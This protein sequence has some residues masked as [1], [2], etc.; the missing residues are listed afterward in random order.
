MKRRTVIAGLPFLLAGHPLAA[1]AQPQAR[2]VALWPFGENDAEGQAL[3]A[4]FNAALLDRGQRE[5]LIQHRWGGADGARTRALAV[6]A[7]RSQ[8]QVIFTYLNAQLRA[9]TALSHTIPLVFVGASD[10]AGFGL[11]ENLSRPGGHVTGF[12]LYE[13]SLGGKWLAALQ[14]AV[15]AIKWATL[16]LTPSAATR[17]GHLY[18]EAFLGT[19]AALSIEPAVVMADKAADIDPIVADLAQCGNAGLI[20]APGTLSEAQ[21]DR[22]VAMTA[23]ARIPTLFAIR[24]FARRG[25]LMSYGPN[26][27]ELVRRAAVYVDRILR[28]ADPGSLPIQAP[29]KYDLIINLNAARS[30]G[31]DI[32]SALLAQADEVVE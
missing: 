29:T 31:Y 3:S 21:G 23:A 28:G 15:P 14:E 8:P 17:D 16:L 27:D 11:I 5:V 2:V 26:P 6:E 30:L 20:V 25:G 9:V 7:I 4:G 10:P 32:S 18:A 24:R 22:I 1:R 19:A 12:T 13:S